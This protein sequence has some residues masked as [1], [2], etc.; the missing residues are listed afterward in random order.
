MAEIEVAQKEVA[1]A[2]HRAALRE[3]E[4]AASWNS[5]RKEMA[6]RLRGVTNVAGEIL[7]YMYYFAY[8]VCNSLRRGIEEIN[9]IL[10]TKRMVAL[11]EALGELDPQGFKEMLSVIEMVKTRDWPKVKKRA[12]ELK[13]YEDT[14]IEAFSVWSRDPNMGTDKFIARVLEPM[15]G[16]VKPRMA[17]EVLSTETVQRLKALAKAMPKGAKNKGGVDELRREIQK[18]MEAH[19]N[20]AISDAD[21]EASRKNV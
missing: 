1:Q 5:A 19:A 11:Q 15:A 12:V 17:T 4:A 21:L 14:F 9:V 2:I 10:K 16:H 6:G 13:I 20:G 7:E 18:T 8:P 3:A